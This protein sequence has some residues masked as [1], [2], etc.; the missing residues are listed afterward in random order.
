MEYNSQREKLTIPEY[1]RHIQKMVQSVL[2]EKDKE[3]RN[4]QAKAI[5]DVMGQ[6]NPHLRDVADFKHKLWDHLFVIS[7]FKLDVDSPFPNPTKESLTVKPEKL[8]YPSRNIKYRHYGRTNEIMIEKA[9][10][11]P[12]GPEKDALILTIANHLKKSYVTWNKDSVDDSKII[13]D[14]LSLSDG[15]LKLD[16]KTVLTDTTEILAANKRKK[17]NAR[18]NNTHKSRNNP[19]RR[20]GH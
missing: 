12:E 2:A 14:L 19:R 5:I 15:K 17:R 10:E 9:I 13:G 16:D 1:G 11:F 3:L 6:L 7:E 4:K 18:S 20:G 8:A